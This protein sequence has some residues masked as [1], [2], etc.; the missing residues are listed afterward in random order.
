M[1]NV[2]PNTVTSFGDEWSRFDQT[3]MS[4]HEVA[5]VFAEYFEVFPWGHLPEN[6]KGL[7]WAVEVAAGHAALLAGLDGYIALT[8]P[9]LLKLQKGIWWNIKM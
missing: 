7:T 2:D 1:T 8:L 5:K 4:D 9:K 6:A 3:S